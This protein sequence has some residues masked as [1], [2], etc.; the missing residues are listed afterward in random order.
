MVM[1]MMEEVVEVVMAVVP[2]MSIDYYYY[3]CCRCFLCCSAKKVLILMCVCVSV[4]VSTGLFAYSHMDFEAD[5]D[6]SLT[7]DPSLVEMTVKALA[8]LSKNHR[9]FFLCVESKYV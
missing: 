3:Y 7:G 4:C 1:L 8:I 5:R 2:I 9:G 6:T